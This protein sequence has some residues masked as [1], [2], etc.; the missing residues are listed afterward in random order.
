MNGHVGGRVELVAPRPVTDSGDRWRL[1]ALVLLAVAVHAWLVANTAV[2]AKDSIRFARHSLALWKPN[3]DKVEGTPKRTFPDVLRAE[4]DPPGYPLAL[5]AFYFPVKAVWAEPHS[6]VMDRAL[7]AGQLASALAAVLTVFPMYWLGRLLFS[8][9]VGF[10]AAAVFQCLPVYARESS[11]AISDGSYL[12]FVATALLLAARG[13]RKPTVGR[14][15]TAGL[16]VGMAYLIRPEG[17]LI[18]FPCVAAV[19]AGMCL[20]GRWAGK[21]TAAWLTALAVGTALPAAPYMVVIGRLTNKPTTNDPFQAPTLTPREK[22]MRDGKADAGGP[23]FASWVPVDATGARRAG[24]AVW[25]SAKEWLK[26]THYSVGIL[27]VVGLIFLRRRFRDEPGL[28]LLVVYG[29]VSAT[30]MIFLAEFRGYVS[31]R[32]ALPLAMVCV[33]FAVAG[34]GPLFAWCERNALFWNG[35]FRWRYLGA[36]VCV[37][38]MASGGRQLARPLH[39]NRLGHKLAGEH[40]RDRLDPAADTLVDPYGWAGFYSAW[41]V[42][43]DG[44]SDREWTAAR[45]LVRWAVLELNADADGLPQPDTSK[46]PDPRHDLAVRIYRNAPEDGVTGQVDEVFRWPAADT[47]ERPRVVVVKQT[48]PPKPTK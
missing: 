43:N 41:A 3:Q 40:L 6:T 5:A 46:V 25:E 13:V 27:G 15:L 2:T 21:S 30:A 12:F 10:G 20:A 14:F 24:L 48:L 47:G 39:D 35:V 28:W 33:Y 9:W 18:L 8:K 26:A 23:P 16:A 36:V 4:N 22:L 38:I 44:P 34:L 17:L 45:P 19:P 32:H 7:L 1:L 37:A 42:Y 29:G 11:D 31:E